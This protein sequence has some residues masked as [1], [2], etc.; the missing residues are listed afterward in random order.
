MDDG[1]WL[2]FSSILNSKLNNIKFKKYK[3]GNLERK[4]YRSE[5]GGVIYTEKEL[6]ITK[7]NQIHNKDCSK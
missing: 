6:F 5:G 1:V 2:K 3:G 4:N 7:T